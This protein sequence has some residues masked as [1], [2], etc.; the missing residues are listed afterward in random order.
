MIWQFILFAFSFGVVISMSP[1]AA[2]FGIIQTSLTKGFRSGVFFA[3]GIALGDFFF[4]ALCLW[5]FA[6]LLDN[7]I[8]K[9]VFG[10]ICGC[11][12]VAYGLITFFSQHEKV[13]DK[14]RMQVESRI[15]RVDDKIDNL[16][17]VPKRHRYLNVLKPM[18][19]GFL[20]NLIN[21]AALVTWLGIM[22]F[23]SSYE[24]KRRAIFFCLI[25]ISIF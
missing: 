8:A 25:M 1:G 24:P 17:A 12:L 10:L 19:K 6:F 16:N 2:F 21:P 3:L 7:A 9:I 5:G 23:T 20:F 15:N 18:A 13:S 22:P 11:V 4:I 14:Q